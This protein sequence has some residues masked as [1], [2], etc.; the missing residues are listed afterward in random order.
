MFD[1]MFALF[2]DLSFSKKEENNTGTKTQKQ[3]NKTPSLDTAFLVIITILTISIYAF[4]ILGRRYRKHYRKKYTG[5]EL[6]TI[7]AGDHLSP[8]IRQIY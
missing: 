4:Y 2:E 1:H 3:H 6:R 7:H 5:V 8:T